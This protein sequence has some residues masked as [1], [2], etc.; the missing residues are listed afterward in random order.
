MISFKI[1]PSKGLGVQ[2]FFYAV[3]RWVCLL[4]GRKLTLLS[5]GCSLDEKT[6]TIS[7]YSHSCSLG[8]SLILTGQHLKVFL[9]VGVSWHRAYLV[10]TEIST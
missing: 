8:S 5:Q 1:I 10:K 2:V 3:P 9:D 6:G 7:V 4:L